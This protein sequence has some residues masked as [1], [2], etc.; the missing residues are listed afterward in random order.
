MTTDSPDI[1]RLHVI[2][3]DGLEIEVP[4]TSPVNLDKLIESLIGMK[5]ENLRFIHR[6]PQGIVADDGYD[7]PDYFETRTF[8]P[9]DPQSQPDA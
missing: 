1:E 6:V 8:M 3:N 5:E 7:G 9:P 2:R 4:Y